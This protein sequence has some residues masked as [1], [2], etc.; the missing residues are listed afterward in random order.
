M[1][2]MRK[3]LSQPHSELLITFM[4][5]Y[6]DMAIVNTA[7]EANMDRL[8]GTSQWK[9]LRTIKQPDRRHTEMIR[10]YTESLGC[11]HSSVLQMRGEHHELKYSII[12]ATNH[13]RGR[14]LMKKVMLLQYIKVII[15]ISK[16]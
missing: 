14:E 3:L 5:R 11:A 2:F 4:V 8:F 6:I 9:Q 12:H 1:D 13:Q 15:Q 7:E 16:S 10:L